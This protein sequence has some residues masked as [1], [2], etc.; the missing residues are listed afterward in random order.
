MHL[1]Q[2]PESFGDEFDS[3]IFQM[4]SVS[5][6]AYNPLDDTFG[7]DPDSPENGLGASITHGNPDISLDT[8]RLQAQHNT[9][10]YRDGI[11]T[12]KA[13]SIQAGFDQGFTLGASIG[14]RAGQ[15]LG[16]LEGISAAL[17]K[18]GEPVRADDL[19]SQAIAELNPESLFTSEFWASDGTWTYPVTASDESGEVIYPDVADQHPLIAKWSRI[20]R[21]EAESWHVD[22]ALPILESNESS[23][24]D[25]VPP[26]ETS[27]KPEITSRDAIE[28]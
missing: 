9:D 3:H 11:T 14:T 12:G 23:A 2:P 20:A 26:P 22:Q 8:R 4:T 10:G 1:A 15:I 28:W 18:A 27:S 21:D 25:D 17:A 6:S 5:P 16:L 19:L 7:A 13:G 24:R